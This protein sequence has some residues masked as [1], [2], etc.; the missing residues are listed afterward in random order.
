MVERGKRVVVLDLLEIVVPVFVCAAIG[1]TWAKLGKAFDSETV[2]G[3]TVQIGTPCL[4]FDTLTRLDLDI[5]DFAMMATGTGLTVLGFGLLALPWLYVAKLDR[6]TFLPALMFPNT[7]NMGLPICLF[8]F[9]DRGL[10]LAISFFAA[11]V[12]LQFTVGVAIASG[13]ASMRMALTSPVLYAVA[14]ALPV[15]AFDLEVPAVAAKTL[16]LLAGFTIPV[17]LIALGV[18]LAKLEVRSLG[19]GLAVALARLFIGFGIGIA[20]AWG[21]GLPAEAAG[22][23]I[24]Q[25]S[26]PIAVF[27]YLFAL[28]YGRRPEAVAGA[29]VLSTVL[30]F[31]SLPVVIWLVRF[32]GLPL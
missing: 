22:V 32:G 14:A 21:L 17:M 7:G 5:A 26:M 11:M 28:R 4:V 8:A 29:V 27:S 19:D 25:S 2:T 31:A 15:M 12:I 10:A 3:L 13:R 16:H 30:G 9:G 18:S 6:A 24:L 23:L 1:W 20:V